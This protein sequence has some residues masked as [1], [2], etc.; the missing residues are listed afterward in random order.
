[1]QMGFL[2]YLKSPLYIEASSLNIRILHFRQHERKNIRI[3]KSSLKETYGAK[4]TWRLEVI[5]GYV[6]ESVP[7]KTEIAKNVFEMYGSVDYNTRFAARYI[8]DSCVYVRKNI[9]STDQKTIVFPNSSMNMSKIALFQSFRIIIQM[10]KASGEVNNIFSSSEKWIVKT[11]SSESSHECIKK[12]IS[13]K[14]C[15]FFERCEGAK[16][17][18]VNLLLLPLLMFTSK[19]IWGKNILMKSFSRHRENMLLCN[20]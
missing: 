16:F 14:L 12:A 5:N 2:F 6:D 18:T 10:E 7:H 11:L 13:Q 17:S 20:Y 1:M 3:S 19:Y 8:N 15:I 4:E 9:I